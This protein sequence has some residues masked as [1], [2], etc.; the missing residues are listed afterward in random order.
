MDTE[1]VGVKGVRVVVEGGTGDDENGGVDE[2]RKGEKRDGKL[3][4][5]YFEGVLDGS[6]GRDVVLLFHALVK[7]DFRLRGKKTILP[8]KVYQSRLNDSRS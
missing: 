2:E 5:G 6:Q 1:D 4:D 8:V 7:F 3:Q